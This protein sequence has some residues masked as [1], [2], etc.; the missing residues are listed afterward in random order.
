MTTESCESVLLNPTDD[1]LNDA[2]PMQHKQILKEPVTR[3]KR[4]KAIVY[5]LYSC[6]N[7]F[8]L[9]KKLGQ[10]KGDTF[11]LTKRLH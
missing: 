6:F 11:L 3:K 1:T 9:A 2:E 8:S 4:G 7:N 10:I 5:E